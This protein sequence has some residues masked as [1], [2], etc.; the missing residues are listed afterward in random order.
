LSSFV[1][2]IAIAYSH[3]TPGI[4]NQLGC[5]EYVLPI[6]AISS[7]LIEATFARMHLEREEVRSRLHRR[8][9]EVLALAKQN[10][11]RVDALLQ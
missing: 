3:K 7:S 8:V 10:L 11:E 2:T 6:E 9:P 5:G 4:M 1:P